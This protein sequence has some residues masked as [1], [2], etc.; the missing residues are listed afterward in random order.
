MDRIGS[1]NQRF[2]VA[3]GRP[4]TLTVLRFYTAFCGS[5]L[6]PKQIV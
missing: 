6:S 2:V 5:M 3:R 4:G 1:A